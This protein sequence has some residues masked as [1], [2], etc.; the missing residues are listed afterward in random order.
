MAEKQREP[1]AQ[2]LVVWRS[3]LKGWMTYDDQGQPRWFR[4]EGPMIVRSDGSV[5]WSSIGTRRMPPPSPAP[6]VS[7]GAGRLA[8]AYG[9]AARAS[10][11]V[12][13]NKVQ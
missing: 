4:R 12:T 2:E 13:H 10:C 3:G 5:A 9:A 7:T 8:P 6:G 11:K 1:L